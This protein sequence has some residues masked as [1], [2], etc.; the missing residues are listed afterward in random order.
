ML[1]P[2]CLQGYRRQS[3][4]ELYGAKPSVDECSWKTSYSH[5]HIINHMHT[6]TL[7]RQTRTHTHHIDTYTFTHTH[8][9]TSHRH[10]HTSHTLTHTH[11][12]RCCCSFSPVC[13]VGPT[14]IKTVCF[15]L[16]DL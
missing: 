15:S 12:R 10:L 3:C 2:C 7:Y 9:H 8:T 16:M 4:Y 6:N 1:S 5:Y 14:P 13:I 11:R